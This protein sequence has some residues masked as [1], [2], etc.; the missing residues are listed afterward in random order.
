MK[1]SFKERFGYSAGYFSISIFNDTISIYLLAFFTNMLGISPMVAGTIFLIARVWDAVNDPIMG[2]MADRTRSKWGSYRPFILYGALPLCVFFVLCFSAPNLSM[3]AKV[4][5]ALVVYI[6][7]GM[8]GTLVGMPYG[9]LPNTMTTDMKERS[10][11]GVGRSMGSAISG[12]VIS[13]FAMRLVNWVGH[14]ET[15]TGGYQVM[16][17][18]FAVLA[19][20][21][22]ML[23]FACVKERVP[24]SAKKINIKEGFLSLKGNKPAYSIFVITFLFIM[25]ISFRMS[26]NVYYFLY[27]VNDMDLMSIIM[28][29]I[30][31]V[32]LLTLF[33]V[34]KMVIRLGKRNMM[35]VGACMTML[36]G[37]FF[38]IARDNTVL[39]FIA[40]IF[41]GLCM[42]FS[43]SVI[44][45][46]L[47]DVADYGEW[48]TGIRAPAF[49]YTIASFFLKCG[50]ALASWLSGVILTIVGFNAA[51]FMQTEATVNGLYWANGL[52]PVVLG[53]AA[54]IA[55]LTYRLT[56]NRLKEI[57]GE[58]RD[59]RAK[60][61]K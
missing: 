1:L 48:K 39:L 51:E 13:I 53:V 5:W 56:D 19:F 31:G 3:A 2:T 4:A 40:A 9:A 30:Y 15:T 26:F 11:L 35:M 24:A 10:V 22:F 45:G 17:I 47:A 57:I 52:Y 33:L 18:V 6:G 42:S 36:S 34:P 37:V 41:C 44:W 27:V 32:Q 23:C 7:Q 54:I 21:G 43:I 16:A 28:L 25:A 46:T 49:L 29:V 55:I 61:A 38:L 14:G 8:L 12:L 59:R 50:G 20:I 58:L 60:A